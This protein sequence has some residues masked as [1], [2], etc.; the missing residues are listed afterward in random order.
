[1]LQAVGH[2]VKIVNHF[3]QQQ[4]GLLVARIGNNQLIQQAFGGELIS[5]TSRGAGLSV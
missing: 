4:P 3:C 2:L 5:A 1:M